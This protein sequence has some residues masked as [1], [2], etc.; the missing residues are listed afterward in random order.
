MTRHVVTVRSDA[1]LDDV[2][3]TMEQHQIRRVPVVD[4]GGCCTGIIAQ[5][6]IV[7][8][9]PSQKGAELVREV[10]RSAANPEQ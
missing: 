8:T 7:A 6:D 3:S 10:S 4:E 5:A 1:P 9:S 2:I